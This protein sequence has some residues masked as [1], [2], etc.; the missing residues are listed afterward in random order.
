MRRRDFL[1]TLGAAGV[2]P[3]ATNAQQPGLLVIGFLSS[4]SSS[5]AAGHV[6]AFLRG[7]KAFGYAEGQN[8]TIEYRWAEGHYERLPALARD[9]IDRNPAV[10][11][12]AG[13]IGSA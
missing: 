8:I 6:A 9:L 7:L 10:I 3:A 5:D 1:I 4:R 11:I 13:G 2:F 12:A